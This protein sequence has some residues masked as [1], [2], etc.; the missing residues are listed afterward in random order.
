[1]HPLSDGI[2]IKPITMDELIKGY[3]TN[4]GR[5]VGACILHNGGADCII[6]TKMEN[7][8]RAIEKHAD[9]DT[10]YNVLQELGINYDPGIDLNDN[11]NSWNK[12]QYGKEG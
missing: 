10:A 12:Y 6:T 3:T 8:V 1:M 11:M 5:V 7:L 9:T 2:N 4:G